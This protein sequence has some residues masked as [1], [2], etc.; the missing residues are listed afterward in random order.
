M[1]KASEQFSFLIVQS[2]AKVVTW[3][4]VTSCCLATPAENV[5]FLGG[6][7]ARTSFGYLKVVG[8]TRTSEETKL[9]TT[10]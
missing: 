4:C 10:V 8:V 6:E 1:V 7:G 9:E 2:E 5:F 3:L